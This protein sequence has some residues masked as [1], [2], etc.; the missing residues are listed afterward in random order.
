VQE[1]EEVLSLKNQG[2][3][4]F[5][6]LAW[7]A[8]TFKRLKRW[9]NTQDVKRWICHMKINYL[10]IW[11]FKWTWIEK[12]CGLVWKLVSFI[13][14]KATWVTKTN[15]SLS[16]KSFKSKNILCIDHIMCSSLEDEVVCLYWI[17][18]V[19]G[20]HLH[21]HY[22]NIKAC[23]WKWRCSIFSNWTSQFKNIGCWRTS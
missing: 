9:P 14:N 8:K 18:L 4:W 13:C 19:D 20:E 10:T 16:I 2:T 11:R 12:R 17:I 6:R 7:W 23:M 15:C 21:V 3:K 22:I 5:K 1:R